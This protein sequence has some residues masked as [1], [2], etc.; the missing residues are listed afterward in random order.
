MKLKDKESLVSADIDWADLILAIG[1]V[2][3]GV[4][5]VCTDYNV[6][7]AGDGNFLR[8]ASQVFSQLKPVIGINSDPD[9]WV[10]SS[11]FTSLPSIIRSEGFLCIRPTSLISLEDIVDRVLNGEVR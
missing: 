2:W 9:K 4:A 3:V 5:G 11:H 10:W 1:G 6:C 8:T 7:A